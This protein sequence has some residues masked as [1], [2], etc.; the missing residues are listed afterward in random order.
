MIRIAILNVKNKANL[1]KTGGICR[2]NSKI[3]AKTTIRLSVQKKTATGNAAMIAA[4]K[5]MAAVAKM[6]EKTARGSNRTSKAK[7][8]SLTSRARG[9]NKVRGSKAKADKGRNNSNSL[10]RNAR[11]DKTGTLRIAPI[12]E[13]VPKEGISI[14]IITIGINAATAAEITVEQANDRKR[15]KLFWPFALI[16]SRGYSY[17]QS[18]RV[19]S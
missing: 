16:D 19:F 3:A 1:I 9:L 17:R 4:T 7:S 14:T 5:E 18:R 13:K 2:K 15:E 10:A 11:P 8:S 12:R 6:E